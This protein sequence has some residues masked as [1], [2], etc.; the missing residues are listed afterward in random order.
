MDK[1]I[2][3]GKVSGLHCYYGQ[4]IRWKRSLDSIPKYGYN[5]SLC[6]FLIPNNFERFINSFGF[7]FSCSNWE[8]PYIIF[9][10]G[11]LEYTL[12]MRALVCSYKILVR[13]K[14]KFDFLRLRVM[15]SLNR[16]PT[17]GHFLWTKYS[18]RNSHK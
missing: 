1:I 4:G 10:I 9:L 2:C 11:Q 16:R 12:I 15:F 6:I 13:S 18:I 3:F 7:T 8:I 5:N 14:R 17:G